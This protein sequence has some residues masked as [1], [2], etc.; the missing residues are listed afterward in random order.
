MWWA[1]RDLR[2]KKAKEEQ[3]EEKTR[4]WVHTHVADAQDS[5]RELWED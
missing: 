2:G 1:D 3:R 5:R 4:R